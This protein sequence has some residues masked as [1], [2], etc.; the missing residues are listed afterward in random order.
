M[1]LSVRE[2][3][4]VE[5]PVEEARDAEAFRQ[6]RDDARGDAGRIQIEIDAWLERVVRRIPPD[7]FAELAAFIRTLFIVVLEQR[8]PD[9]DVAVEPFVYSGRVQPRDVRKM[10]FRVFEGGLHGLQL[11][12]VEE[13][14]VEAE[15][16]DAVPPVVAVDEFQI[17]LH[18]GLVLVRRDNGQIDVFHAAFEAIAC[19]LF[20]EEQPGAVPEVHGIEA[21]CENEI[22][23][24]AALFSWHV[25][26]VECF[27]P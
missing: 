4:A 20:G 22:Q 26:A 3:F 14:F 9:I 1:L 2:P 18:V 27:R 16:D 21:M 12:D 19:L 11:V 7:L 24:G 10:L 17:L 6:P 25:F 5:A 15:S 8:A 13:D 23:R